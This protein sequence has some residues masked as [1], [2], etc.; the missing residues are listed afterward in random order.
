M[1]FL[2]KRFGTMEMRLALAVFFSEFSCKLNP[3]TPVP[4]TI[5]R[6]EI[7][8]TTNDNIL[9]DIVRRI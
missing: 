8:I 4:L 2:G 9:I 6:G 1:R 7:L 5:A 3:N